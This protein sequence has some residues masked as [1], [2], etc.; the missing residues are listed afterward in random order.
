MLCSQEQ[1]WNVNTSGLG[2]K[3]TFYTFKLND[4]VANVESIA[5]NGL[6][7]RAAEML[8]T[9]VSI[10][11]L[12]G[13]R[14]LACELVSWPIELSPAQLEI[15]LRHL[16]EFTGFPPVL[17]K[18]LTGYFDVPDNHAGG[19]D[20]FAGLLRRLA[21]EYTEPFWTEAAVFFDQSGEKLMELTGTVCDFMR[22]RLSQ[23]QNCYL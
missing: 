3:N 7:K 22:A 11:G 15:S 10:L 4:C 13:I 17:P 14:K 9:P 12:K 8:N 2:K 21:E 19:R 1:A 23:Q 20:V 5:R 18:R 16:V 6:R